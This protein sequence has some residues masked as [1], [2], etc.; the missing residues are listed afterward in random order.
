MNYQLILKH[1][2]FD[3]HEDYDVRIR[4][5]KCSIACDVI[6]SHVRPPFWYDEDCQFITSSP[7]ILQSLMDSSYVSIIKSHLQALWKPRSTELGRRDRWLRWHWPC[8]VQITG[9]R[10]LQYLHCGTERIEDERKVRGDK[11]GMQIG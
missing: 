5:W 1:E 10:R 7:F 2:S 6:P 11:K 8:H 9:Q 4:Q 3:Q